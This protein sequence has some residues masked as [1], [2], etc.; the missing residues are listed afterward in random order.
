MRPQSGKSI[1][2]DGREYRDQP[3]GLNSYTSLNR[4]NRIRSLARIID[5]NKVLLSKLQNT[6]S[7]YDNSKWE[8]QYQQNMKRS[9]MISKNGDRY[10]RNPYFLNSIC[11]NNAG[12]QGLAVSTNRSLRR[13]GPQASSSK[14]FSTYYPDQDKRT[15][16]DFERRKMS[17]RM[18]TSKASDSN[19]AGDHYG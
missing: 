16:S 9:N 10:C 14:A 19:F 18:L 12:L 1:R 17:K 13:A 5:E 3:K 2:T 7:N 6:R 8:T 11:T 15:I 4:A